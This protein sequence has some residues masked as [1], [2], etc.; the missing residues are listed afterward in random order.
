MIAPVQI[1]LE[2]SHHA[3][4][5]IGG[6]AWVRR[7]PGGEVS[8]AAGGERRID[9]ERTGLL[10]LMAAL[11]GVPKVSPAQVWS[12]SAPVLVI[13]RVIAAAQAAEPGPDENLDLWAQVLG[14][15]KVEGRAIRPSQ[16]QPGTPP[17]FAA[18]WAELARDRAKDR[19]NFT[20]PIPKSNLAKS[21]A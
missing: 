8:G 17:A 7:D 15:L 6:W 11:A 16:T 10:A 21:G 18:A 2:T 20:S 19:G 1:W 4:F 9:A 13:P 12:A 3:A 14:A 5:R